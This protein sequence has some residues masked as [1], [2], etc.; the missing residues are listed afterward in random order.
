MCW[1]AVDKNGQEWIYLEKPVKKCDGR[2]FPQAG[3]CTKV[4]KLTIKEL[5]GENMTFADE[6]IEI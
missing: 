5:L 1:L 4:P 2:W 3:S 6:P